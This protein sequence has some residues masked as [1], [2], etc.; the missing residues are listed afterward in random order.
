MAQHPA[1]TEGRVAVITGAA[2]GIGLAAAKRFAEMGL[3]VFSPISAEAHSNRP[4]RKSPSLR[5]AARQMCWQCRPTSAN[6]RKSS[7]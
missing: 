7:A 2:S 5:G 3:R 6:W 4:Q 1:L